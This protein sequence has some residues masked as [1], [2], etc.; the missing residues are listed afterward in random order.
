MDRTVPKGAA[1]S[2]G[3][4][5]HVY[6]PLLDLIGFTE[7][8]DKG[9]GYN[10]TLA[11]GKMLDGKVTK[12][13]A[14][15][16][17]LVSLTLKELDA[18]Q[19][20]MLSDPDNKKLNSSAAGRY[21]IVRTTA[22]AIRKALPDRYPLTRE[23][24][25]D[26]QD[27]MACY[28]LGVRGIDKYLAGRLSEDALIDNL[29]HEWASLPK[30]DGKGAY[31]GQHAAISVD[32]LRNC[33]SEIRNRHAKGQP[34]REV[35]VEVEKPVVP[36]QVEKEVRQKTNWF[37]SIFSGTGFLGALG[38][39]AAGVDPVKLLI[40]V[41]VVIVAGLGFLA[42]GEWIISRIK[43]IQRAIAA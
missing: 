35:A 2:R 7:G 5:Y 24:D 10:E 20:K 29:A 14:P 39:W 30:L 19:T 32:R 3:D 18:L 27:E 12:G 4:K 1:L 42:L 38:A 36:A 8:T 28:L 15:T 11:Y 43:S 6:R 9:R 16:V 37:T 31:A 41:A 25:A 34:V 26:C 23:F 33:L 21:Q 22:R 13:K 40:I 17:D